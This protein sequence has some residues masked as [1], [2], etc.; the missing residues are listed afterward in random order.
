MNLD[1]NVLTSL[2]ANVGTAETSGLIQYATSTVVIVY[3][4]MTIAPPFGP[5]TVR[6]LAYL[7]RHSAKGRL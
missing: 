4:V 7:L 6:C 2:A 3:R 5:P 1:R